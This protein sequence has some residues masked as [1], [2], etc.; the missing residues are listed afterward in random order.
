[1]VNTMCSLIFNALFIRNVTSFFSAANFL[2][3]YDRRTEPMKVIVKGRKDTVQFQYEAWGG[4]VIQSSLGQRPHSRLAD[5][6]GRLDTEAEYELGFEG[7]R[8]SSMGTNI[9]NHV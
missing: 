2:K 6:A 8:S 1:M 9:K 5:P 4:T 7:Y 3:I